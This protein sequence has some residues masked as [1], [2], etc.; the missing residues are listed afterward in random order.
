MVNC[1]IV[2]ELASY[3]Y[4]INRSIEVVKKVINWNDIMKE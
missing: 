4:N 2:I 3:N 1:F